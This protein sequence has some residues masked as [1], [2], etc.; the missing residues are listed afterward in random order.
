[1]IDWTGWTDWRPLLPLLEKWKEEKVWDVPHAP[2]AYA[3]STPS[4]IQR[5]GGEDR[6]GLLHIG[7]SGDLANRIWNFLECV[8]DSCKESHRAGWR[9]SSLKM[10]AHFPRE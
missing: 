5:A 2:G 9:Y 8:Q 1:M 10:H 7:E 3:V 4:S 6:E